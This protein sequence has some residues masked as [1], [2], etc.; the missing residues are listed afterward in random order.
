VGSEKSKP[1]DRTAKIDILFSSVFFFQP[2]I[3]SAQKNEKSKVAHHYFVT[4]IAPYYQ[5]V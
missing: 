1:K 3:P 2:A 4:Y 5:Q